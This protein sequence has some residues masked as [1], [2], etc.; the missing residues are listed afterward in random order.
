MHCNT[1]QHTATHCNTLQHTATHCNTL[2][3]TALCIPHAPFRKEACEIVTL[4]HTH[5][6]NKADNACV[7]RKGACGIQRAAGL[8]RDFVYVWRSSHAQLCE[9]R[10][11]VL[12]CVAVHCSVTSSDE[13]RKQRMSSGMNESCHT[14]ESVMS[15]I[16]MSHVTHMDES[17]CTYGWVMSHICTINAE[18]SAC[19]LL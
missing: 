14:Y 13:C 16:W 2:Q 10:C 12:Q 4:T 9:L 11:S 18:S 19:P 5:T 7:L 8:L 17:C 6:Q 15:H 3:H 1:L